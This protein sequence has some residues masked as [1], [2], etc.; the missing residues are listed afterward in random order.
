M[1]GV[2]M[3]AMMHLPMTRFTREFVARHQGDAGEAATA[4]VA[5][6]VAYDAVWMASALVPLTAN[7]LL[8]GGVYGVVSTHT[9]LAIG[10]ALAFTGLYQLSR[11]KLTRL[12]SCCETLA[13]HRSD[14]ASAFRRGLDHGVRCVLV[15][16]GPFFLLMP[17]FGSM[18]F[19]WMVALT[20]VVGIER[21]P[22]WG[23][24]I[25]VSTGVVSL[26]AGLVVLVLRPDL[27]VAFVAGGGL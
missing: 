27:P 25:A 12:R 3:V 20:T 4:L 15:C 24:E 9:H 18:N 16:F 23:R 1:W 7:A 11:F 19:L 26:V 17:V 8:P 14:A 22:S 21:L 6:L 13:P 2:M 5:F 10:G